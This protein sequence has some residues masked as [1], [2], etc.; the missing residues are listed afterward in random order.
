MRL[1]FSFTK[2]FEYKLSNIKI[3]ILEIFAI[4]V[5]IYF[6]TIFIAKF[7]KTEQIIEFYKKDINTDKVIYQIN[8][9][10]DLSYYNYSIS[11]KGD[12][13]AEIDGKVYKIKSQVIDKKYSSYYPRV[14]NDFEGLSKFFRGNNAIVSETLKRKYNLK[15]GSMIS[16]ANKD[17]EVLGFTDNHA[18]K[19]RVILPYNSLDIIKS[20][21]IF[22]YYLTISSKDSNKLEDEFSYDDKKA[23]SDIYNE[24]ILSLSALKRFILSFSIIFVAIAVVNIILIIKSKFVRES[25][26]LIN[27]HICGESSKIFLVS[28]IIDYI[29]L[30]SLSFF[31][32]LI[33][34]YAF[35]E[36]VPDFFY[37]ELNYYLIIVEYFVVTL[38][39]IVIGLVLG[40]KQRKFINTNIRGSHSL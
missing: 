39:S 27:L 35:I 6:A 2:R 24:E 31:L 11:A 8:K 28:S 36:F 17:F 22:K 32:S 26:F 21:N 4:A 29:F 38:L 23:L 10:Y 13:Y 3:F 16:I 34:H 5:V 37:F 19:D 12:L 18:L 20:Q 25:K 7:V 14:L 40:Y 9:I 15:K 33:L 1:I 30:M